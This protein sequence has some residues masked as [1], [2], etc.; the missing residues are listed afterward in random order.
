MYEVFAGVDIAHGHVM[1][2]PGPN[3]NCMIVQQVGGYT[4]QARKEN[5]LPLHTQSI[6]IHVWTTF[7]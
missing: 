1:R 2:A 6:Q 7:K 3:V 4:E 5:L